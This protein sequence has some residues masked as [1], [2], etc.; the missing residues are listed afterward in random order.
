MP[1]VEAWSTSVHRLTP[2][3]AR[4][5][6]DAGLLDV[7]LEEPPDVWKLSTDSRIGVVAAPGWSLHVAPRLAVPQ[8]MFLLGYA[9]DPAGWRDAQ[10]EFARDDDFFSAIANGFAHHAQRAVEPAPLRGYVEVQERAFCLRGRLRA[11]DQIASSAGIPIPLEISYDDYT[12]DVPE[13]RVLRTA[14]DLLLRFAGLP[15]RARKRLLRV[16]AVLEG[17]HLLTNYRD[18]QLPEITRLNT[19]YAPALRLAQLILNGASISTHAGHVS[20]AAFVFDM[21]RVFEDFLSAALRRALERFGGIVQTQYRGVH[22][23]EQQRI[24]VIPDI[25][26]WRDGACRA[27]VD[28]KYKPLTDARFPNADAYQ[29][30]A[31]CTAF[32]LPAGTLVYARDALGDDRVHRVRNTGITINVRAIDVERPPEDLLAQVDALAT[33]LA[34][35]MGSSPAPSRLAVA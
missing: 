18:G 6:S 5:A 33:A 11:A 26:W 17:A 28:A 8:L 19:R 12:I 22:L 25:V 13:N 10:A 32:G 24:R 34:A 15:P 35:Q 2:D 30:L 23:D 16:R 1:S 21:N 20:S 27:I 4:L 31:Y 9:T 3:H 14:A 7:S 29:M